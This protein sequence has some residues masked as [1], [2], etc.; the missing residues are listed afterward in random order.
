MCTKILEFNQGTKF[1]DSNVTLEKKY[2]KP[3][4]EKTLEYRRCAKFLGS[5]ISLALLNANPD[6]P[7]YK[8]YWNSFYCAH[9]VFVHGRR[10]KTKYCKNKWCKVCNRIRTAVL[11]NEYKPELDKLD[12]YFVTL[13]VP[14]C[15]ESELPN[16]MDRM[17]KVWRK[18]YNKSKQAKYK[19]SYPKLQ[20]IR[21]AECTIRPNGYYHFHYHIL[22]HTKECA[23]WV[24]DQW[25]NYFPDAKIENQDIRKA[26]EGA[27]LELFKYLTKLTASSKDKIDYKRLDVI[28]RAMKGKQTIFPFGVS[29]TKQDFDIDDLVSNLE[30]DLP[31]GTLLT[32]INEDWYDRETG[33]A[34]VDKPLPDEIKQMAKKLMEGHNFETMEDFRKYLQSNTRKP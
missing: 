24:H 11:I 34:L 14:T 8:S 2:L 25:L 17:Q 6:S 29:K 20:G 15:K 22:I 33:I 3:D 18:L 30:T 26:Y 16:Q 5:N 4:L 13:T 7:L 9:N 12:L 31:E 19:R 32:W 23:Q 27:Y 28:F 21:K 10:F 1:L